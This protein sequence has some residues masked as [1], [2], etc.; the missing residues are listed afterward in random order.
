MKMHSEKQGYLTEHEKFF[1]FCLL[2]GSVLALAML[3]YFFPPE[4]GSGA[5]R[6][7]DAAMGGLLLALGAAANALFRIS[8]ATE[9]QSIAEKTA[10]EIGNNPT[11]LP[12]EVQNPP[13][14]PVPTV[15]KDADG[16]LPEDQKL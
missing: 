7:I 6:I 11:P 16:E 9:Q 12:V 4:D 3:A 2:G 14:H 13:S 10:R 1:A 15:D 5:Q 8:N